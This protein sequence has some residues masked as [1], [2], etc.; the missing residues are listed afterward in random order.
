MQYVKLDLGGRAYTYAWDNDDQ[1][2]IVGDVVLC[3]PN[4][5]N[6]HPFE[7]PVIRLLDGPD[8]DGEIT[9]ILSFG[10]L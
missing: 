6:P 1:P 4:S 9:K 3:P 7:A 10:L 5:V 2:L 8:Y